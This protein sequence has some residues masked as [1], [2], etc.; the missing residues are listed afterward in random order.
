MS[1]HLSILE[2]SVINYD[3]MIDFQKIIGYCDRRYPALDPTTSFYEFNSYIECC[4]SLNVAPSVQRFMRYQNY[5][6]EI[7]VIK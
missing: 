6:K 1:K 7:G 2:V 5:I 4:K 3:L